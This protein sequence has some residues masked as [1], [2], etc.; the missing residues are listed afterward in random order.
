M[1]EAVPMIASA[2][3]FG[4]I[5]L[6]LL[7]WSLTSRQYEDLE[8]AAQR[9]LIDDPLDGSAGQGRSISSTDHLAP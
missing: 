1:T 5:A 6:G 8:G 4:V 7:L 2:L 3:L 9:I